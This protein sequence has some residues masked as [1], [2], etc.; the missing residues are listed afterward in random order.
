MTLRAGFALIVACSAWAMACTADSRD[1]RIQ[2]AVLD[3]T[4]QLR[5]ELSD[6]RSIVPAKDSGQV[7]F[8]QVAVSADRRVAGWVNLYPNCC[9][10]YPIPL[11]LVLMHSTG[12]QTI[13]GTDLPIWQWAF[14][15]SDRV[16]IRS[17]PVH[18][19]AGEYQLRDARTGRL[20]A[21]VAPDSLSAS[22]PNWALPVAHQR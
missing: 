13:I 12:E 3:S 20:I 15:D 19:G 16:V 10:S 6:E 5:V 4:G 2:R 14:A 22:L 8:E 7:A 18:G 11:K 17:G 9:T 1:P 21:G